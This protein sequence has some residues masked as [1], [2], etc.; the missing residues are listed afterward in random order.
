MT[1]HVGPNDDE[2]LKNI[3]FKKEALKTAQKAI[4]KQRKL[5]SV[6]VSFFIFISSTNIYLLF[7][8]FHI[9]VVE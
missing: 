5:R 9:R 2:Y 3:E 7:F 6:L 1:L 8:I 4:F